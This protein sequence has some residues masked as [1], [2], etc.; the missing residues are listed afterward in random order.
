MVEEIIQRGLV[1]T[2]TVRVW[3]ILKFA[4]LFVEKCS[5][6]QFWGF[7]AKYFKNIFWLVLG[8]FQGAK[9]GPPTPIRGSEVRAK[10]D[11]FRPRETLTGSSKILFS[12]IYRVWQTLMFVGF[13]VKRWSVTV[14]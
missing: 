9:M 2:F 3:W 7:L 14:R 1:W 13:Y 11:G 8:H 12:R 5:E 10:S 4:K 6:R